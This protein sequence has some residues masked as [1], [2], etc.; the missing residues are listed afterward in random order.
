M[1]E[2]VID[3]SYAVFDFSKGETEFY[4]AEIEDTSYLWIFGIGALFLILIGGY[5]REKYFKHK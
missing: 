3:G 2:T 1:R 4:V 5:T